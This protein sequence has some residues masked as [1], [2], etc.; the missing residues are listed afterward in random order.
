MY[1]FAFT[2]RVLLDL[3]ITYEKDGKD[4]KEEKMESDTGAISQEANETEGKE[5]SVEQDKGEVE[6]TMNYSYYYY[7]RR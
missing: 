7:Y 3:C 4:E 5:E 1:K 6:G 2:K